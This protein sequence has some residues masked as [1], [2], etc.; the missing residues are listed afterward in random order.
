MQEIASGDGDMTRRLPVVSRD[1]VGQLAVQFN[2]FV[3]KL[4]GVLLNVMN[5]SRQLEVAAHE[6]SAGNHDLSARTE[7]QAASIEQTS[8]AMNELSETVSATADQAAHATQVAS[9]AVDVARRGNDAVS[10]AA[11]T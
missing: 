3:E 2:A 4:H 10:G 5:N 8:A 6:V 9:G 11:R 7:Q 1:E